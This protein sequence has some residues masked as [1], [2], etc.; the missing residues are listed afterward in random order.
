MTD[1]IINDKQKVFFPNL[2]GL[3]F[4]CFLL[5][6]FHHWNLNCAVAIHDSK[7]RNVFN[8]LFQ[9]GNIGVNI[10]FVL[11][12]FLITF[13]LIKEKEF[14]KK[15]SLRYFYIRRIF[16]IWPL[17]YLIIAICFVFYPLIKFGL[18]HLV[19]ESSNFY[20]YLAFAS[21]F[22][23]IKS[24]PQMPDVL[25]VIVLWSV[26]VEEQ[27]YLVWPILLK[28]FSIGNYRYIFISIILFTLFFR[29]MHL[30]H[31]EH[32]FAIRYFHT[33]SVIGDMAMGGLMAYYCSFE[34][35]IFAY[36]KNMPRFHIVFL[37]SLILFLILFKKEI[38]QVDF[39]VV[40]ERAILAIFFAI[41]IAE[42]N[43]AKNSFFKFSSYKKVSMLGVYTYGLYC[44][45]FFGILIVQRAFFKLGFDLGYA[46]VNL[47]GC[48]FALLLIILLSKGSYHFFEK[49]FLKMKDRFAIITQK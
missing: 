39:F 35:K 26:S 23:V 1:K 47:A 2:D 36:I 7:I 11:S 33:F 8:F 19:T 28:Y 49:Y 22:D 25:P 45:Q 10:F 34:N 20:Y 42:Q 17:Y 12:G 6:F 29:Y 16:R 24:Y 15:I 43:F 14:K 44:L 3:R 18:L 27:F 37:Y 13:L 38:F 32:D 41:I 21:N 4:V 48:I 5:V 30:G 9:N 46:L 40:F 31:N